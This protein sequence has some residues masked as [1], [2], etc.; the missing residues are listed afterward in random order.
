VKNSSLRI[1]AA[2]LL[3]AAFAALPALSV[4]AP[5]P[6]K[7]R[8]TA[9]GKPRLATGFQIYGLA[10]L[11]DGQH[12]AVL[13]KQQLSI[14]NIETGLIVAQT[15]L[16]KPVPGKRTPQMA[17]I[18]NPKVA[19]RGAL[20]ADG[21]GKTISYYHESAVYTFEMPITP[22]SLSTQLAK[23]EAR[24][25]IQG[26]VHSATSPVPFCIAG[27]GQLHECRESDTSATGLEPIALPGVNRGLV[28]ED[29]AMAAGGP[30]VAIGGNDGK[31]QIWDAKAK[32]ALD[33][34][35]CA[36]HVKGIAITRD[37]SAIAISSTDALPDI[38]VQ[39]VSLPGGTLVAEWKGR[40]RLL[41]FSPDGKMLALMRDNSF[42][43]PAIRFELR[44]RNSGNLVRKLSSPLESTVAF[45]FSTDGTKLLAG[46]MSG[47]VQIWD[48]K[49]GKLLTG[50]DHHFS[51]LLAIAY[52]MD[53]LITVSGDSVRHWSAEGKSKGGYPV[54]GES[55]AREAVL[56]QD[57]KIAYLA[58]G[59]NE[60]TVRAIDAATGRELR[61]IKLEGYL[62][63]PAALALAKDGKSLFVATKERILRLDAE[64]FK[65]L[66][67]YPVK[68][69]GILGSSNGRGYVDALAI[70]GDDR[71]VSV[72]V[73]NLRIWD[74]KTDREAAVMK[75]AVMA[76][77]GAV[78][79]LAV[80]PDGKYC[81]A[82][83]SFL[84]PTDPPQIG[85]WDLEKAKLVRQFDAPVSPAVLAFINNE[86][87]IVG[88][89]SGEVS[90]PDV[91]GALPRTV[92]LNSTGVTCLTVSSDRKR[93]AAGFADGT[94][95]VF[96]L[97]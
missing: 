64:T 85:I 35:A 11:P 13:D 22:G 84:K 52:T 48:V 92:K 7:V 36:Q 88:S 71:L 3:T 76:Y 66:A 82:V 44:D 47:T 31:V 49:T 59:R 81:A 70:A 37:G 78:S 17:P 45:D 73:G 55:L 2:G 28:G 9:F 65:T 51:K 43:E 95:S 53:G 83:V 77:G 27:K 60:R 34:I 79:P 74:S 38:K 5:E 20:S 40:S 1:L 54:Y 97:P 96:E 32:K 80:S 89:P 8:V 93:V 87:V 56:S 50:T 57:G 29:F 30:L 68:D 90:L 58:A 33:P 86:S 25:V 72:D 23:K 62:E 61:R 42:E 67:M 26:V 21:T 69:E 94:A 15:D 18:G 14:W 75:G 10:A 39:I 4:A 46:T 91:K 41:A 16:V 19:H 6:S 63:F 12:V 24:R